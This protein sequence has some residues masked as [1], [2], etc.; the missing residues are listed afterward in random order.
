MILNAIAEK[1][2]RQSQDDFKGRQFEAWLI[3]QAVTWYLRYPLSYRDL[4]EMFAERGF[5][6]DHSTINRWVLTC[7]PLI[8]KRLRRFRR[9]HCGSIRIEETYVKVRGQWRYLY[10]AID[11]HGHAVDFLLTAKRDAEDRRL[12]IVQHRPANDQRLRGHALAEKGFRLR[13]RVD[14]SQPERTG[15]AD[16]RAAKG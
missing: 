10:R 11:K 9:P 15:R 7:A 13:R 1:L 16:L 5:P 4:E 8:D 12:P 3:V 2:K 14:R 6:V